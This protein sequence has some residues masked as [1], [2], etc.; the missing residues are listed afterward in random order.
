MH[1]YDHNTSM[2]LNIM[3]I[4]CERTANILQPIEAIEKLDRT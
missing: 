1:C 3:S 4:D 2:H